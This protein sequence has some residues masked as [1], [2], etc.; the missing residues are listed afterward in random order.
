MNEQ[1][2]SVAQLVI[3]VLHRFDVRYLIGGSIASTLH[4]IPRAT[5]DVDLLADLQKSHLQDF[6]GSL[7]SAFYVSMQAAENAVKYRSSFNLI[8]FDTSFKIDVFVPKGRVFD[9][10]QFRNR[11]LHVFTRDPEKKAYVASPEDSILSKLEWYRQGAYCGAKWA[12][13][14]EQS[15]RQNR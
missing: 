8:H 1:S 10:N 4:G 15:G 2:N 12:T 9:E 7:E 3:D 14:S 6:C 5:I 13:K 11:A